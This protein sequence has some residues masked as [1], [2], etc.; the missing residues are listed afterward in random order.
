MEAILRCP[1]RLTGKM[2][3]QFPGGDKQPF[4][5]CVALLR[6]QKQEM[7]GEFARLPDEYGFCCY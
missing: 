1:G 4:I 5:S 2:M 6:K 7:F 3:A